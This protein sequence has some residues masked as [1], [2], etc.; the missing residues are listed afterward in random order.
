LIVV[1]VVVIGTWVGLEKV[2]ER[3]D[4]TSL[5]AAGGGKEE[6][7]EVRTDAARHALDL[8]DV[9]PLVGT[10]GGSFY[11]TYIRYRTPREGY[12]DHAHNDY[13][14]LASEY[15]VV[16]MGL[17][18]A[19]VVL[20]FVSSARTMHR[21]RSSLPRGVSFGVMMAIVALAIHSTVDFNLQ[22]PSNALLLIVVMSMGWIA[23]ELPSGRDH[24]ERGAP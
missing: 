17:L 12:F 19:F 6:S 7:I 20:T 15:G 23:R 21:R 5:T 18:G 9:F 11:N 14:E 22:L 1:D 16:G 4:G 3:L 24:V 13:A 8:L 2:V 10:G